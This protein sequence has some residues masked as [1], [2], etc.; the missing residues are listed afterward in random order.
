MREVTKHNP[1]FEHLH[2]NAEMDTDINLKCGSSFFFIRK[3]LDEA[4]D[5][6]IWEFL[7][8]I[9]CR[10]VYFLFNNLLRSTQIL[11][12]SVIK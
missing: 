7:T 3:Y 4:S 9:D 12:L 1:I 10:S 8:I 11:E 5:I 6:T 2:I